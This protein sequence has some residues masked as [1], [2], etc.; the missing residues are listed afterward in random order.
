V[1]TYEA[2]LSRMDLLAL[3]Y[4]I[5][6]G[7]RTGVSINKTRPGATEPWDIQP[8]DIVC[9]LRKWYLDFEAYTTKMCSSGPRKED[10]ITMVSFW[11]NY[12]E[13]LYTLYTFNPMWSRLNKSRFKNKQ[14]FRP[15]VKKHV[16]L[17]FLTETKL[18]DHLIELVKTKDPDLFTAWNLDR[19]DIVKWKQRMD[20]LQKECYYKFTELNSIKSKSMTWN[21]PPYR[22]KGRVLFDLMKAYKVFSGGELRSY[23]LLNVIKEEEFKIDKVPFLGSAASTWDKYPDVV[24][25]RNVNDVLVLKALDDKCD[26]IEMFD[27]L[28]RE[29]G[30]LFHEALTTYRVI[31]TAL[32]RFV[33]GRIVL[34]S[35]TKSTQEKDKKF[36]GAVV[37]EPKLGLHTYMAQFDFSREYPNIIKLF[38][39]GPESYRDPTYT[40]ECYTIKYTHKGKEYVYKFVKRPKSLL[41][42]LIDFFFKKRDAYEKEYAKAIASGDKFKIKL[43]WRRVYNVKRMTNGIYGV[44]DYANFRLRK[45]ECSAAVAV[46]GRLSIEELQRIAK[47]LG[48]EIAYGDTDSIFI[49]LKARD[50]EAALKE[51][52]TLSENLNKGLMKYF[53]REY[54][55]SKAPSE[56][57]LKQIYSMFLQIAKKSYAGKY[58]WDEKKGWKEDYNFKGLEFIRSDSS[59][60]EKEVLETIVKR[61]LS[62]ATKAELLG[63]KQEIYEKFWRYEYNFLEVAYPLQIK[64]RFSDYTKTLPAHVAAAIYSN[65]FLNTDFRKGDKPRRLP[66]KHGKPTKATKLKHSPGQQDLMGM[67]LTTQTK[68][69]KVTSAIYPKV[70]QAA[71]RN[72]QL[73]A[74]SVA[75]DMIVP[76]W[77]LDNIDWDRIWK[78]L[79][80]KVDRIL[81]LMEAF[82]K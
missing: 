40:G 48:Y 33:N 76:K 34:K 36:L 60:L 22:I 11:D 50:K 49:Q 65:R 77:F 24:F 3:R 45:K 53:T 55:V 64:Y 4:M 32:M 58:F 74:I 19:Y 54:D 80:E 14:L 9:K 31:D 7:I 26:L 18:L 16:I 52:S 41:A 38:N 25:R 44:M 15:M 43:W 13:T 27:D 28:R 73:R 79:E 56:L 8:I 66:I 23:S 82:Y 20:V 72:R 69:T 62:R 63:Y 6:K 47:L 75:E 30:A 39:I 5:D 68:V 17:G 37:I 42:Q 2:D 1:W 21:R 67:K 59:D 81:T 29:F 35:V 12:E 61:L 70:Y 57:S 46:I 51:A 10:A 71:G 78:R